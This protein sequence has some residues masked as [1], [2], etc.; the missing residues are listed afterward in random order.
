M[1]RAQFEAAKELFESIDKTERNI[2]V[3]ENFLPEIKQSSKASGEIEIQI[4]DPRKVNTTIAV[5]SDAFENLIKD[6]IEA[7]KAKKKDMADK[8]ENM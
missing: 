6:E 5:R 2:K 1:K 8:L 3:L 4:F 7:M